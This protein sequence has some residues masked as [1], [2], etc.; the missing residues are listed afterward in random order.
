M[1][2][3]DT[4]ANWRPM[5]GGTDSPSDV[6]PTPGG[7]TRA[8]MAPEPRP[9]AMEMPQSARSFF[10]ARNSMMRAL[11][12]SRPVRSPSRMLLGFAHW[13]NTAH[14]F[15]LGQSSHAY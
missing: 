2:P 6:L 1:R 4:L 3:S 9:P 8:M 14:P 12:P 5:A 11:T 7:P 10:T 15:E 13:Y